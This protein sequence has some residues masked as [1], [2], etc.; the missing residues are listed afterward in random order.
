MSAPDPTSDPTPH[1]LLTLPT[2]LVST[3]IQNLDAA[4]TAAF[5]LTS[6]TAQAH[7]HHTHCISTLG[8]LV[9]PM[10]PGRMVIGKQH[11]NHHWLITYLASG[12]IE[13]EHWLKAYRDFEQLVRVDGCRWCEYVLFM[14]RMREAMGDAW[15]LCPE[16][17][18][19]YRRRNKGMHAGRC[20]NANGCVLESFRTRSL[21]R[22][23]EEGARKE[24]E[25]MERKVEVWDASDLEV[26]GQGAVKADRVI[27]EVEVTQVAVVGTQV[28]VDAVAVAV[29]DA[30]L[31]PQTPLRRSK[32]LMAKALEDEGSRKRAKHS[33]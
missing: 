14:Y 30:V 11:C 15:C 5:A 25:R 4:S 1:Q 21:R 20:G 26:R 16:R 29:V 19:F 32:R 9:P 18:C 3:I 17:M 2:E 23:E 6:R 28:K 8:C 27:V 12:D 33:A 31:V 13:N 24:K 22:L 7:V 10:P